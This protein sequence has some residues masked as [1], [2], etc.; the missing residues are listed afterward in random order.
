MLK[1]I[2][3]L[4]YLLAEVKRPLITKTKTHTIWNKL[5]PL[6]HEN[7]KTYSQRND[8]SCISSP[9]VSI[10]RFYLPRGVKIHHPEAI[11][12]LVR[13]TLTVPG[14][15]LRCTRACRGGNEKSQY[16]AGR[17]NWVGTFS[18]LLCNNDNFLRPSHMIKIAGVSWKLM[19]RNDYKLTTR[20]IL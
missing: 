14:V 20:D 4:K 3:F 2:W 9:R 5:Y 16:I 6:E 11:I 10:L 12:T 17:G 19:F 13:I 7:N 8:R 18:C 1:F 15:N